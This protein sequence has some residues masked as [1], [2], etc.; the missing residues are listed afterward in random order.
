MLEHKYHVGQLVHF[1]RKGLVRSSPPGDFR[2][3]RLLPAQGGQS[4][5]RIKSIADGH[6]R[7]VHETELGDQVMVEALAQTLYEADNATG[8]PWAQRHRAIREAWLAAARLQAAS[9]VV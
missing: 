8:V 1:W 3:E 9:Q 4:Q 2:V 5:Y 6:E 7:V